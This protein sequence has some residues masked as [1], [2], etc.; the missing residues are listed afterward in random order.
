MITIKD[1]SNEDYINLYDFASEIWFDCY[2]NVIPKGQIKLLCD[3]YF[4]YQN[5]K[6]YQRDGIVYKQIYQNNEL[7]G[8]L[9]YYNLDS[10]IYLDKLYLKKSFQ[11]KGLAKNIFEYLLNIYK[12]DILL[13]VNQKNTNAIK[14]Y[15]KNAF[16]IIKED[17]I[18][19]D[20]GYVNVDYVM[21]R[22]YQ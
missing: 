2:K 16:K 6:N 19:L 10:H 14:C 13:N 8:F 9:A 17:I 12:K 7:C 1:F 18:N 15:L 4:T 3:K 21:K 22:K 20:D 11:G 5:I